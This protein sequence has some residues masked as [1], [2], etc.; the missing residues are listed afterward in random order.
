MSTTKGGPG[1]VS[2]AAE[3]RVRILTFDRPGRANAFDVALYRAA[4]AALHEADADDDVGAVVL[5][6][7]GRTFTAG[8]D[9]AE[10]ADTAG[11][12]PDWSAPHP[13]EAFLDAVVGF[14][15]PLVAAVNGPAVGLGLTLLPHCDLVLVSESARLRAPFTAMGV[16]PEAAS[17]YLLAQ[18][19]GRQRATA[20][21]LTSDWLSATEAVEAGLALR[22]CRPEDLLADAVALAARIASHPDASVRATRALVRDAER[23]GIVRARAREN[24]AFAE[25]LGA[26]ATAAA[27]RGHLAGL[28]SANGSVN[29]GGSGA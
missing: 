12:S 29:G 16:V 4:A 23:D 20:A 13:F 19:M 5:T 9:L 22:V 26:S 15:K 14:S 11:R 21:L 18:R 3:G 10:M 1:T 25:I 24:A 28:G 6:G 2:V 7:A 8:T 17:S 27:I